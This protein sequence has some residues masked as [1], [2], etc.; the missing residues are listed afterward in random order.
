MGTFKKVKIDY[1]KTT[2]F[3]FSPQ[4]IG[5]FKVGDEVISKSKFGT[6]TPI[7]ITCLNKCAD[8][9]LLGFFE[10]VFS[11]GARIGE[12]IEGQCL[13]DYQKTGRCFPE[14]VE[15][16]MSSEFEVGDICVWTTALNPI[17]CPF[18]ITQ[19]FEEW[20]GSFGF[21]GIYLGSGSVVRNS[22]KNVCKIGHDSR[23]AEFFNKLV[24][25]RLTT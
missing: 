16:F 8:S 4:E 6:E 21:H 24:L 23:I 25:Y 22:L 2:Q 18:I 14:F 12:R 19:I 9:R 1:G 20:D 11:D 7:I 10:G 3:S 13:D 17:I 15:T 5:E